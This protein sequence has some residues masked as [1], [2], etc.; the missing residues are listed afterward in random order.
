MRGHEEFNFPAF[1][2]AAH[3]LRGRGYEVWS[4]AEHDLSAG[5]NPATDDASP[6]AHY[7]ATD[8][9]E[10]CRSDAVVVLPGWETSQGAR[11]EIHVARECG[12]RVLRY[13]DLEPVDVL[14]A[15]DFFPTD[16]VR[17][18]DPVTGGAKGKKLAR[19]D[20]IPPDALKA[21]A[22]HFGRGARKY[23]DRNWERGYAWSLTFAALNRHL[24]A[25]WAG[26]DMDPDADEPT[27]HVVAAAWH[28]MVLLAFYLRGMGTDDRVPPY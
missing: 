18:V 21:L 20:L 24:W 8:L 19:Y 4:P 12:I 26:E 5:F 13:P 28:A 1:A 15:S 7:M 23:E 9:A 27:P 3:R 2:S 22:E 10:V 14:S 25:F 11:L 6:L 17:V 16:E